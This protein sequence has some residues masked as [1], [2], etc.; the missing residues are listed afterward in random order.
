VSVPKKECCYDDL[1]VCAANIDMTKSKWF[2]FTP[3]IICSMGPED[4]SPI[5]A[6]KLMREFN[7][8]KEPRINAEEYDIDTLEFSEDFNKSMNETLQRLATDPANKSLNLDEGLL[9]ILNNFLGKDANLTED[10]L[11][12]IKMFVWSLKTAQDE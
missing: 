1:I 5:T 3:S 2:K 7:I 12:K 4:V 6:I 11:G 10:E 9:S 8:L